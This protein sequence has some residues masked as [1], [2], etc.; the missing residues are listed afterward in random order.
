MII[1]LLIM[2]SVFAVEGELFGSLGPGIIDISGEIIVPQG[3]LL[4]VKPGTVMKFDGFSGIVVEG[5]IKVLG[6][7]TLPVVVTSVND[8][9]YGGKGAEA[10]DW[11]SIIIKEG[12]GECIF[13]FVEV[14]YS[15]DCIQCKTENCRFD[16]VLL[17]NNGVNKVIN[18]NSIITANGNGIVS[19]VVVKSAP[20]VAS[21]INVEP[22]Q[23]VGRR[24][25]RR[26]YPALGVAAATAVAVG[27]YL[28]RSENDENSTTEIIPDPA[29]PPG[30]N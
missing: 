14:A 27:L 5:S 29:A 4:E 20:L 16:N 7:E 28:Y 21:P 3:K 30:R 25:G 23:K 24:K 10:L 18:G 13:K 15:S 12:A 22:V 9:R 1:I 17:R 2:M 6:T 19:N 26:L 11:N 8:S